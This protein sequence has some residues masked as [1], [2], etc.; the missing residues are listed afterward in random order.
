MRAVTVSAL[1]GRRWRVEVRWLPWAP[2]WRG[3]RPK[4]KKRDDADVRWYDWIDL[5]EPLAW[6]D[7]GLAGFV[8]AI[9]FVML[10][11]MAV[12]LVLPAFIFLVELL[13][14][15]LVLMAA[16]VLRVVFRRPWIL[17][18]FPLDDP[19]AHL[20]WKV[21]GAGRARETVDTIAEQLAAGIEVPQAPGAD[22]VAPPSVGSTNP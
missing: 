6:F 3:P 12:L 14:V 1:D 2:R 19:S 21:V 4:S 7:D 15:V 22:L 5:A 16:V 10:L 20:V 11:V 13:I 17:D 9:V 8:T 18:A